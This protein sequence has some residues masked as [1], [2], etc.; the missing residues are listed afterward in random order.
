MGDLL[1]E[2]TGERLSKAISITMQYVAV[3]RREKHQE[4]KFA[5]AFD[6]AMAG[7]VT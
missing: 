5:I 4:L 1:I 2:L 6:P 7:A 3:I